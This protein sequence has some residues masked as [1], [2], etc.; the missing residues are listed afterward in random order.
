MLRLHRRWKKSNRAY[1]KHILRGAVPRPLAV[2]HISEYRVN[3]Q[4]I[5]PLGKEN[6]KAFA[7][8]QALAPAQRK[9]AILNYQIA[10]GILGPGHDGEVIQPEG[11]RASKFTPKQQAM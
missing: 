1:Q 10:D 7:L 3:G 8:I 6:D 11:V 2:R 5:R 9:E 4:T